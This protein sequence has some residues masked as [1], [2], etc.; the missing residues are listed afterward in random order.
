MRNVSQLIVILG[1][2]S[3]LVVVFLGWSLREWLIARKLK[4]LGVATQARVVEMGQLLWTRNLSYY[5]I[6]Q[7][8]TKDNPQAPLERR[9][10]VGWR[11]HRR[12]KLGDN[13]TVSYLPSNPTMSRLSNQ[14]TDNTSRDMS[15]LT[16]MVALLTLVAF[17]GR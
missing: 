1:I 5:L 8:N 3:G 7:F 2:G 9:Q 12:L 13:V 16:A 17:L 6:Y 14:D 4:R 11:H 15:L 10:A